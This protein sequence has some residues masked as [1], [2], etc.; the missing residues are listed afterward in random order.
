MVSV[1]SF[2]STH[3]DPQATCAHSH[4]DSGTCPGVS[5]PTTATEPQE[6]RRHH[7]AASRAIVARLARQQPDRREGHCRSRRQPQN[8]EQTSTLRLSQVSHYNSRTVA[9]AVVVSDDTDRFSNE[10]S[11]ASVRVATV[12]VSVVACLRRQQWTRS[13]CRLRRQRHILKPA[14]AISYDNIRTVQSFLSSLTTTTDPQANRRLH[15]GAYRARIWCQRDGF[16]VRKLSDP[17]VSVP[18]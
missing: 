1:L 15:T 17:G 18:P 16:S 3:T 12:D 13:D 10:S 4:D 14:V 7:V 9:N 6:N 2:R 8:R 5:S 11:T